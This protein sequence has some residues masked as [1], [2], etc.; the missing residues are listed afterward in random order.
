MPRAFLAL[1][2][3]LSS[4]AVK[5]GRQKSAVL[6]RNILAADLSTR[7]AGGDFASKMSN[8]TEFSGAFTQ[9]GP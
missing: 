1:R 2:R 6:V 8:F 4:A 9:S 7:R 3:A 5:P